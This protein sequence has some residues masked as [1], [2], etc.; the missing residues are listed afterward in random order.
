MGVKTFNI[1]LTAVILLLLFS[2]YLFIPFNT[3]DF[4]PSSAITNSNFSLNSSANNTL[5]FYPNM[6]FPT[7]NISYRIENCPLQRENDMQWAFSILGNETILHF[8]PVNSGEEII[9]TC[10]DKKE[11]EGNLFIAGEGGPTNITIAGEFNVIESGKIL[12]MQDSSCQKPNVAI[13]E[14]LHVLGFDHSKNPKNIM[15]EISRCDQTIG[16]DIINFID[17]IYSIP[18]EPDLLFEDASASMHG[19][20]L[21]I[22]FSIRNDGLKDAPETTVKIMANGKEIDNIDI[23]ATEIG[24]GRKVSIENIWIKQLNVQE[25]QFIIDTNY[26]ELSKNNNQVTFEIKK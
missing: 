2:I 6:R 10:Q 7:T 12:L 17:T 9:V 24:Y 22:N 1:L 15:Y 13:H 16:D 18:A 23:P 11:T 8:Y 20:Y 3:T 4:A 5:Q 14:L 21:N 19:K 26:A 25:I